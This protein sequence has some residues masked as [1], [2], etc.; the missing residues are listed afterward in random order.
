MFPVVARTK[1]YYYEVKAG[2]RYLWCS[3]GLS[4]TQPFCDGS[5]VDTPLKPV[6]FKATQDEDVIFCG[7]KQTG[8]PPFCDGAH[9][10]LDGGYAYDDPDSEANRRVTPAPMSDGPVRRLDGECYV[11]SPSRG[12]TDPAGQ[13]RL[14]RRDQPGARRPVPVPVL[15]RGGARRLAGDLG[16]RP[17]RGAVHFRRRGRDRDQRPALPGLALGRRLCSPDRGV[18]RPQSGRGA[19]EVVHLQ[20]PRQRGP[21]VP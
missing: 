4:K 2:S 12:G 1:G 13:P 20:R 10:N 17:P 3:C 5:H 11:F 14:L 18:P 19:D 9:N 7:C 21:R 15:R 6:L 16:R 8:T